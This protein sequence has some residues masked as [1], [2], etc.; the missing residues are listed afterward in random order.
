METAMRFLRTVFVLSAISLMTSSARADLMFDLT[1]NGLG[2]LG[3]TTMNFRSAQSSL[4]Q[5]HITGTAGLYV[6]TGG[7]DES[8]LGLTN[9]PSGDHEITPGNSIDL[10]IAALKNLYQITKLTITIGS[11]QNGENYQVYGGSI[12]PLNLLGSGVSTDGIVIVT[13]SNLSKYD[14]YIVTTTNGNILVQSATVAGI[15]VPEPS[16]VVL[17][18]IGGTI[19]LIVY[20][21]R[22]RAAT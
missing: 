18:G 21:V 7:G 11:V 3:V 15:A 9:D 20:R 1:E 22:K 2:K 19:G 4:Y 17:I 10:N 12:A 14:D 8:G 5:I 13:G 16:G 6:K